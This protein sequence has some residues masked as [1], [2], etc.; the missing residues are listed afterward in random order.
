MIFIKLTPRALKKL[1]FDGYNNPE[2][3]CLE[4]LG[5]TRGHMGYGAICMNYKMFEVH[6]V[7]WVMYYNKQPINNICHT[8]DNPLCYLQ[9]HLFDAT[10]SENQ[11]DCASKFRLSHQ[12][13]QDVIKQILDLSPFFN[14]Y[15]IAEKL[16]TTQGTVSRVLKRCR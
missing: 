7:A 11:R 13:S 12:L 14:Q 5:C 2:N 9:E 3:G 10:T 15:Y 8:C 6:R 16:N 1:Q 4:W